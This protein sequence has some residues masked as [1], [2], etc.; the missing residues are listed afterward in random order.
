MML[1]IVAD[2][3]PPGSRWNAQR[4]SDTDLASMCLIIHVSYQPLFFPCKETLDALIVWIGERLVTHIERK[5]E[6]V[7]PHITSGKGKAHATQLFLLLG[8]LDLLGELRNGL[9]QVCVE[10]SRAKKKKRQKKAKGRACSQSRR[11][12]GTYRQRDRRRRP[13]R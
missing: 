6:G 4:R 9:E 5:K 10:E 8:S 7:L 1:V 3:V 2:S 11:A 12:E 13:G